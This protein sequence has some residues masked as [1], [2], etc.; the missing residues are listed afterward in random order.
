[1][2]K[3]N[4]KSNKSTDKSI[5]LFRSYVLIISF[6]M[7]TRTPNTDTQRVRDLDADLAQQRKNSKQDQ[8]MASVIL[9]ALRELN[10]EPTKSRKSLR[11]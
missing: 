9:H 11:M 7:D 4:K 6:N 10:G 5:N 3:N 8:H 2:K 1:M